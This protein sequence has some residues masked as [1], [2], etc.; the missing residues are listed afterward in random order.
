[1]KLPKQPHTPTFSFEEFKMGYKVDQEKAKAIEYYLHK[2]KHYQGKEH[3]RL[4]REQWF[5]VIDQVFQVP[6]EKTNVF[7]IELADFKQ[8]ANA[9]LLYDYKEDCDFNILHFVSGLIRIMRMR[10]LRML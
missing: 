8:I 7:D 2:Y 1:M 5:S 10:D 6:D 4:K 3:P 9:H